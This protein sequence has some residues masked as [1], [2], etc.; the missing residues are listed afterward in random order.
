[1]GRSRI[2]PTKTNIR[3]AAQT[4]FVDLVLKKN[5]IDVQFLLSRE[6]AHP[7]VQWMGAIGPQHYRHYLRLE[8]PSD[9]DDEV[10]GW[11]Q[12]SY[13]VGSC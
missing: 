4:A 10:R 12:D 8:R 6:L 5:W 9:V 3:I 11:M 1:M 7:R 13:T 2:H